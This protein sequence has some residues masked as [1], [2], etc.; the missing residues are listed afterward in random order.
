MNFYSLKKCAVKSSVKSS[1]KT[2][3]RLGGKL[4]PH[5]DKT[6]P[7]SGQIEAA[8]KPGKWLLL[9]WCY[10][11]FVGR[12]VY[13]RVGYFQSKA[14]EGAFFGFICKSFGVAPGNVVKRLNTRCMEA[15][16]IEQDRKP[17]EGIPLQDFTL[18]GLLGKA[19]KAAP[20]SS[21][22]VKFA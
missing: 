19:E 11:I 18:L 14:Q 9:V 10:I 5:P 6:R 4:P 13:S 15:R 3:T 17:G 7:K 16:K 1:V 21:D 8:L 2:P 20:L 22:S 12:V